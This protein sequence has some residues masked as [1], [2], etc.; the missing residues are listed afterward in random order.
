MQYF[1]SAFVVAVAGLFLVTGAPAHSMSRPAPPV[2]EQM[3]KLVPSIPREPVGDL[4]C[5][6]APDA[7]GVWKFTAQGRQW[8]LINYYT[9]GCSNGVEIVARRKRSKLWTKITGFGYLPIT[10]CSVFRVPRAAL[11]VP[12]RVVKRVNTVFGPCG[13]QDL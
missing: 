11:N 3:W 1:R 4:P 10:P 6:R 9:A 13:Q 12:R 7:L 8:G 2:A 5:H